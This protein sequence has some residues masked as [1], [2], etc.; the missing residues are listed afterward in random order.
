M[1]KTT[2]RSGAPKGEPAVQNERRAKRIFHTLE[3]RY[4]SPETRSMAS[5]LMASQN[6]SCEV[7]EKA[8]QQ[9]LLLGVA[10]GSQ[11]DELTFQS[12]LEAISLDPSFQVPVMSLP[13]LPGGTSR[14]C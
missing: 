14:M 10:C 11:T 2:R 1:K 5:G 3:C 8:L 12:L 4:L 6:I 13:S 9:A 7:M